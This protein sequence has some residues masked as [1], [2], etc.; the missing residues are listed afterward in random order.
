[1]QNNT[2]V[3]LPRVRHRLL[4][5][6]TTILLGISIALPFLVHLIPSQTVPWGARFLPIFLAPLLG[7]VLYR[8]HVGLVPAILAP[9]LNYLITGSPIPSVVGVLTLELTVFAVA[10]YWMLKSWP[11][12]WLAGP[13]GYLAAKGASAIAISVLPWL[14]S[15][16]PGHEFAARSIETAIPGLLLLAAATLLAIQVRNRS[17]RE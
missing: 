5:R 6:E 14:T 8:L 16:R 12:L 10:A 17:G 4:V 7:V 11:R 9:L 15:L 1:M 3:A 2:P 13:I